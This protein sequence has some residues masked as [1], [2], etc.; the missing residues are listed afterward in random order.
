VRGETSLGESID[1]DDR[2]LIKFMVLV[3]GRRSVEKAA[4]TV[5]VLDEF[6]RGYG[7]S[8]IFVTL[9][10]DIPRVELKRV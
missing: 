5:H 3:L 6:S 8:V 2:V 1:D 10:V 4:Y 7:A 9:R